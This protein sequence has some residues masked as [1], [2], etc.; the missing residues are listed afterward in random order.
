MPLVGFL[1]YICII[2][3]IEQKE[4]EIMFGFKNNDDFRKE[5]TTKVNDNAR[6]SLD[7]INEW[8]ASADYKRYLHLKTLIEKTYETVGINADT[9]G[10]YDDFT[11]EDYL[12][13][14]AIFF[15]P[16]VFDK[17]KDWCKEFEILNKLNNKVLYGEE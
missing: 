11:R 5:P 8:Y 7:E 10:R 1:F 2:H 9:L 17:L 16:K 13:D 14:Y 12:E 4:K 3:T 6:S 15:D